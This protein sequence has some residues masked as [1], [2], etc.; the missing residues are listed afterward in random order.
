MPRIRLALSALVLSLTAVG[1]GAPAIA[2]EPPPDAG[3]VDAGECRP[4]STPCTLGSSV[5]VAFEC[6]PGDWTPYFVCGS[7]VAP[8]WQEGPSGPGWTLYCCVPSSEMPV[9]PSGP[10]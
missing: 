1:C 5:G 6:R 7:P 9:S 2:P 4:L 3:D 10:R 8:A